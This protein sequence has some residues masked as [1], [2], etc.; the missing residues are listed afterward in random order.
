[1]VSHHSPQLLLVASAQVLLVVLLEAL[2]LLSRTTLLRIPDRLKSR[3]QLLPPTIISS[4][5]L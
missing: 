2:R 4:R 1:M 3:D 5:M